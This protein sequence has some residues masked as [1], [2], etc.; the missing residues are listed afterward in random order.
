MK[1]K[2]D[3]SSTS[4]SDI[5]NLIQQEAGRIGKTSPPVLGAG[6]SLLIALRLCALMDV[7]A[8]VRRAWQEAECIAP[9]LICAKDEGDSDQLRAKTWATCARLS[10]V[11]GSIDG[12]IDS[13]RD[14]AEKL[15]AAL[16]AMEQRVAGEKTVAEAITLLNILIGAVRDELPEQDS[17]V[18]TD[19]ARDLIE[20]IAASS[21]EIGGIADML[22]EHSRSEREKMEDSLSLLENGVERVKEASRTEKEARR[23][24]GQK[25]VSTSGKI[26]STAVAANDEAIPKEE[27][28]AECFA[29]RPAAQP[30]S[31]QPQ[32]AQGTTL[33]EAAASLRSL[34]QKLKQNAANIRC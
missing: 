26:I 21:K 34:V 2:Y 28:A 31:A 6:L 20:R 24:T 17:I 10:I 25:D 9:D 4:I 11:L 19:E 30:Q 8:R 5:M 23:K 29:S 3:L 12:D 22:R 16:S 27:K 32:Q 33:S 15:A 18:I 13:L 1:F 14:A 7:R